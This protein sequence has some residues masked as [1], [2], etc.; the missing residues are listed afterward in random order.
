MGI[1]GHLPRGS[2]AKWKPINMLSPHSL[3]MQERKKNADHKPCRHSCA[4]NCWSNPPVVLVVP[5]CSCG[6]LHA[7][8]P[9]YSRIGRKYRAFQARPCYALNSM[10][11]ALRPGA[12]LGPGRRL[13]RTDLRTSLTVIMYVSC[14]SHEMCIDVARS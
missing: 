7:R 3:S 1:R 5:Q 2:P 11:V 4:T 12:N 10:C 9:F 13:L 14:M 6:S 8:T